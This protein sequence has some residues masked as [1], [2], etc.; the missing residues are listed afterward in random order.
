MNQPKPLLERITAHL[1]G[2]DETFRV[3]GLENRD[4]AYWLLREA[5]S[6]VA[7]SPH[8]GDVLAR[9]ALERLEWVEG[10]AAGALKWLFSHHPLN[11][12]HAKDVLLVGLRTTEKE[13]TERYREEIIPAPTTRSPLHSGSPELCSFEFPKAWAPYL[14]AVILGA[15]GDFEENG[16]CQYHLNELAKELARFG[17]TDANT[18]TEPVKIAGSEESALPHDLVEACDKQLS[19]C[20]PKDHEGECDDMPF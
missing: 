6:A 3:W 15:L 7:R 14:Q 9:T 13:F 17:T 11:V 18:T 19:C 16:D 2:A 5:E 1:N 10:R 4:V 8:D 20:L 12:R